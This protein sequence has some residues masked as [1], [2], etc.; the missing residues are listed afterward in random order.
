MSRTYTTRI[1]GASALA[2]VALGAAFAIGSAPQQGTGTG[3][4]STGKSTGQKIDDF[5]KQTQK[6]IQKAADKMK[7]AMGEGQPPLPPGWTAE[8]MQACTEAGTPGPMHAR[9]AKLVGTWKGTNT[10]WMAPGTEP[11]VTEC[12]STVASIMDGRYIQSEMTGE[13][14]GM[15]QFKGLGFSGFDNVSQKF[16][17]SWLDNHSTGI[18]TGVGELAS[19]G[20]T[21]NWTFAYNCPVTKKPTVMREVDTYPDANTMVIDMFCTDPK[22]SKEFK[23]MRIELKRTGTAATGAR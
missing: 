9:L 16:V 3:G 6:E 14:P 1:V 15:G 13:M 18:M 12:T 20:S 19:D 21:M 4:T 10:M 22:S 23:C 7:E 5:S 8:D 11:M 2:L 17:G